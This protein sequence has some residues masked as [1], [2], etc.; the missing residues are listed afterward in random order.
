MN[1]IRTMSLP[2]ARF[3]AEGS[4][5]PVPTNSKETMPATHEQAD[6]SQVAQTVLPT[7]Q[8]INVVT[9]H[10]IHLPFREWLLRGLIG[11][12]GT[13]LAFP[14]RLFGDAV[15]SVVQGAIGI[16]KIGIIIVLIPTLIWL[17]IE[18][19]QMMQE[20][21]SVEAGAAEIVNQAGQVVDGV[22]RGISGGDPAPESSE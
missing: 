4:S 17:G 7:G 3:G 8:N 20:Q 2:V 18:L 21:E 11:S 9:N 22:S 13:A 19:Q 6:G 10:N 14:F 1:R 12:F 16:I 15:S 5:L